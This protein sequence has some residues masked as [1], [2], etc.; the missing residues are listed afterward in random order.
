M[1]LFKGG[2][3]HEVEVQCDAYKGSFHL[4]RT[5]G[6]KWVNAIFKPGPAALR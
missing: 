5:D 6:G 3:G 4:Q 1:K 2:Q